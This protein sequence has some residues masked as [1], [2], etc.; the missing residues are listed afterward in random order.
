MRDDRQLCKTV[1]SGDEWACLG[2]NRLVRQLNKGS[3]GGSSEFGHI[4]VDRNGGLCMFPSAAQLRKRSF[5][6]FEEA[7]AK[8]HL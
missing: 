8:L 3:S 7:Q 5:Y 4:T 2:G 6:S 1:V